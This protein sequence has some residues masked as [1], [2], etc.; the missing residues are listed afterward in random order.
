MA[1]ADRYELFRDEQD[2]TEALAAFADSCRLWL[3]LDGQSALKP[4]ADGA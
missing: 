3:R 1:P 2:R 4:P